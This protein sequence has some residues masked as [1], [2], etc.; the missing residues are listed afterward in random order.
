[1]HERVLPK[2]AYNLSTG[3]ILLGHLQLT[4]A[5][6]HSGPLAR[7]PVLSPQPALPDHLLHGGAKFHKIDLLVATLA[8]LVEQLFPDL[9]VEFLPVLSTCV[10]KL[11]KILV[12]NLAV[13]V[14]VN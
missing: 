3:T 9:P 4:A 7:A 8:S 1:M 14:D 2:W 13:L 12:S 5:H 11:V 6:P 10:E